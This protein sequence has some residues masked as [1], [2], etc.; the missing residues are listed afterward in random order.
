MISGKKREEDGCLGI[1]KGQ[2]IRNGA[3]SLP[4][5]EASVKIG[6]SSKEPQSYNIFEL[7]AIGES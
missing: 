1:R 3:P 6:S 7:Y 4:Q 2:T 5:V